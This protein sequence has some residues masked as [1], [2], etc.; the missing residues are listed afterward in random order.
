MTRGLSFWNPIDIC[1]LGL[2]VSF[3]LLL[4]LISGSIL[5]K[6]GFG[7][8]PVLQVSGFIMIHGALFRGTAPWSVL[9][10]LAGIV[11]VVTS[12]IVEMPMLP[13]E[14]G[15]YSSEWMNG[16]ILVLG[17][18]SPEASIRN[19]LLLCVLLRLL[20]G[21]IFR[22]IPVRV[23]LSS[24][25]RYWRLASWLPAVVL[26]VGQAAYPGLLIAAVVFRLLAHTEEAWRR[27]RTLADLVSPGA[28][29]GLF[30]T[31]LIY[32]RIPCRFGRMRRFYRGFVLPGQSAWD[33]GAHLGNRC[34]V[35]LSL[36]ARV[37]A[38]EPQPDCAAVLEN[39]FGTSPFFTLRRCAVGSETG[40]VELQISEEHPTLATVSGDWVTRMSHHPLFDG[41]AW[42]RS[43]SVPMV[44]LADEEAALGRP[45]FIKIDVEGHE[46]EVIRGL[47]SLPRALSFELLPV[48]R[49][50]ALACM[51]DLT[52]QADWTWNLSIGESFHM[53]FDRPVDHHRMT[54][55]ILGMDEG[56]RSG[57]IYAQRIEYS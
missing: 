30:R 46:L 7:V 34:R 50:N 42:N 41:I 5:L 2:G 11:L 10:P 38:Y 31:F 47:G 56:G 53:M 26:A 22:F 32:Y 19:V 40:T 33:V 37:V 52:E 55:F 20:T 6:H 51:T 36:G 17:F 29:K 14:T 44:R 1:I 25:R 57:D 48:D 45:V 39:W 35:W 15:E 54:E 24:R 3:L 21:L 43:E 49:Q 27:M 16:A 18:W 12:S 9:L 8:P 23:P 13:P 28:R 4:L